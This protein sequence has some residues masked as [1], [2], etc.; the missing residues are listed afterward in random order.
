MTILLQLC[1]LAL[2]APQHR[3]ECGQISTSYLQEALFFLQTD[4]TNIHQS[5]VF[6]HTIA[7]ARHQLH[8]LCARL[9]LKIDNRFGASIELRCSIYEVPLWEMVIETNKNH[10]QFRIFWFQ[11]CMMQTTISMKPKFN[12]PHHTD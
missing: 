3:N 2:S 12:T 10:N 1:L 9:F 11:N 8:K 4:E 5:C 7:Y 6:I